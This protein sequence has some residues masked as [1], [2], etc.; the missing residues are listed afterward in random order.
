MQ[1]L[2]GFTLFLGAALLFWVQ[3]FLS[4]MLLPLLGG[5]AAVW[6]TCLVFFQTA[7][8]LGYL[9]AHALVTWLPVR[10]RVVIHLV[11]L[12]AAAAL[13]PVSL[14]GIGA[15][16][17][18]ANPVLWL[19]R[20]LVV[21][22]GPTFVV[23]AGTAP[24]LQDWFATLGHPSSRDPYFLYAA[25]NLGSLIALLSYPT[26]IER[27]LPLARQ[28]LAWSLLYLGLAALTGLCGI[29]AVW[30]HKHPDPEEAVQQGPALSV[31]IDAWRQRARWLV[32]AFVP[33][34][35][36]LGVTTHLTTDIAAAPLFWVVPLVLYLLTFVLAFQQMLVLPARLTQ[37]FQALLIVPL[38]V[39]LL[40]QQS[41]EALPLFALHLAAF[42]AT[43]LLCHQQLAQSRP[44]A[45]RLTE[46]YLLVAAGGAL[47]GVFNALLAPLIFP[48]VYEYPLVLVLACL[49]RPSTNSGS[50]R[51]RALAIDLSV[52]AALLALLIG[53]QRGTTLDLTDTS[54]VGV[55]LV[56]LFAGLVVF[57]CQRR[58][59]RFGLGIAALIG[60]GI[61]INDNGEVLKRARNF[62]GV[63]RVVEQETPPM[64][65]LMHG[66]TTHGEQS[67]DAER[68]RQPLSYYHPDGPLGQLFEEVGGTSATKHVAVVGL[69]AGTLACYAHAGEDWT[70]FEINPAIVAIARDPSFFSFLSDCPAQPRI[71]MGDARLSLAQQPNAAFDMIILDAFTSDAIP[72]HLM[73]REAV[74]LYLRKLRT[75]GILV[76][77]ISNRFLDLAPVLGA[78]GGTLHLVGKR[79]SDD[80]EDE[81][82][83]RAQSEW[84]LVAREP[85]DLRAVDDDERWE[86]LVASPRRGVWTDEYSN[87][88]GALVHPKS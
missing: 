68:R 12:L 29:I 62:Y 32:L 63:L 18:E 40:T 23:L 20:T 41:D 19:L 83:G 26:E 70:F 9:Y 17:G 22:I 30:R 8:L 51:L 28:S 52:P 38:A 69:G 75:G 16:P 21:V 79:W 74:E 36:L 71:V 82:S 88:L 87:V 60:A 37:R 10:P 76:F 72:V 61:V 49:L 13:L 3:L 77:H 42:F 58:P 14:A 85:T 84:V 5:S 27:H 73:T 48:D 39:T 44:P 4:K 86:D 50:A 54:S 66:T 57:G 2:F 31:Q 34:S 15:P 65:V 59:L 46:F 56:L 67:L 55:F 64:H 1:A 80:E 33:S 7:L 6:N 81:S 78:I 47:G 35:L 45:A 24:I 43:A 53:L 11:L 25:S